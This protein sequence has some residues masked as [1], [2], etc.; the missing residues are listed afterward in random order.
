M[1]LRAAGAELPT[2]EGFAVVRPLAGSASGELYE[3][4]E[5][6]SDG[7]ARGVALWPLPAPAA[8]DRQA[9]SD[10]LA[11]AERATR[12]EHPNLVRLHGLREIGGQ[13]LAV[14]ELARGR[15]LFR[16]WQGT[17]DAPSWLIAAIGE[18]VL[19]ALERAHAEAGSPLVH[20]GIFPGDIFVADD[21]IVRLYGLG[22]GTGELRAAPSA[23]SPGPDPALPT[24]QDFVAPEQAAGR[25]A[26]PGADLYRLGAVLAW[27]SAGNPPSR[28]GVVGPL[29]PGIDPRLRALLERA[30]RPDPA[31]RFPDARSLRAEMAGLADAL[32]PGGAAELGHFVRAVAPRSDIHPTGKGRDGDRRPATGGEVTSDVPSRTQ[33]VDPVAAL[34]KEALLPTGTRIG[35]YLLLEHL[36]EGGMGVVYAAYDPE[37]NR[38]IALKL[39]RAQASD[40][41]GAVAARTRLL[42]EAQAMARVSHPNVIAIYD[43]GALEEHVFLAMELIE[44]G[45]LA[46]WLRSTPR[47]WRQVVDMYRRAGQGLEAAHQAGLVHRDFKPENVLVGRDGRPRVTDFGLARAALLTADGA[48]E[49]PGAAAAADPTRPPAPVPGPTGGPVATRPTL[50]QVTISLSKLPSPAGSTAEAPPPAAAG[51][52]QPAAADHTPPASATG[53]RPP[54]S[55][56]PASVSALTVATGDAVLTDLERN[57]FAPRG[58]LVTPLTQHGVVIG[59]PPYMAPEQHHSSPP[60]VRTDQF[61]FCVALYE[62]LYGQ[63]PCE[64]DRL[65]EL[66]AHPV[67]GAA[68]ADE[69]PAGRGVPAWVWRV[70]R[71]GLSIRPEE[72]YPS[73]APLLEALGRDPARRRGKILLGAGML[74]A[75]LA[76]TLGLQRAATQHARLCQGATRYLDG[77]WDARVRAE[78]RASFEQS[79][80]PFA[81]DSWTRVEARLDGYSRDWV[82]MHTDACEATR[83]RGDQSDEVLSLRMLC[84]DERQA[85]LKALTQVLAHADAAVVGK[86]VQAAAALSPIK[87]CANVAALRA[88]N[89]RPADPAVRAQADALAAQ[90]AG[91]WT[92][93]NTGKMA[94]ALAIARRVAEN[95]ARIKQPGIEAKALL[96]IGM[97]Q[98]KVGDKEGPATLERSLL[99]AEAAGD[100]A[101]IAKTYGQLAFFVGSEQGHFAEG[102]AYD[103]HAAAWIRELGGSDELESSRLNA[104]GCLELAAGNLELAS[105]LLERSVSVHERAVGEDFRLPQRLSNLGLAFSLVGRYDEAE[106]AYLRAIRIAEKILGPH[107]PDMA[108]P[109]EN[110]GELDVTRGRF[111]DGLLYGSKA[112]KIREVN[113]KDYLMPVTLGVIG[114]AWAGKG[115][116]PRAIATLERALRLHTELSGS[117][118]L[119]AADLMD[120][121]GQVLVDAGRPQEALRLFEHSLA[122]RTRLQAAD[123]SSLTQPLVGLGLAHL[124]LHSPGEALGPLERALALSAKAPPQ[125]PVVVSLKFGLARTLW[126]DPA[127]RPRARALAEE[128]LKV[129]Q[130]IGNRKELGPIESWLRERGDPSLARLPG[131]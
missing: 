12:L 114:T 29:S 60:D 76:A 89:R 83:L 13:F 15:D 14:M 38:R 69:P 18:Q 28:P 10:L 112:L 37:L 17:I 90:L 70:V 116:Y 79:G 93:R 65:R 40:V 102:R 5:L 64:P 41:L 77:V 19:A 56:I 32:R 23:R 9:R 123:S 119:Q 22:L 99:A 82:A 45:T 39:L 108:W 26:D 92:L 124:A 36:G 105:E 126:S 100:G 131:R 80:R 42:R 35:R 47:S 20:G 46:A 120:V 94:D 71:R 91:A 58:L 52:L 62:A 44:G 55:P 25:G 27:L 129:E 84:L 96:L 49:G 68:A 7:S 8:L 72:R 2:F 125:P 118:D 48:P 30:T 16:L 85:E 63:R 117:D 122:S 67:S 33:D 74:A 107:H 111:D 21:G 86:A 87:D 57:P 98:C 103:R 61:S 59:T 24:R 127:A 97:A 34:G 54:P 101:A 95:A 110:L 11:G 4:L 121:F 73:L 1:G 43:V 6:R 50:E 88:Q 106:Q 113:P 3:A 104:L 66:G 115:D 31:Q 128:A 109:L 81:S 75:L 51:P 130:R 53:Q 78:V